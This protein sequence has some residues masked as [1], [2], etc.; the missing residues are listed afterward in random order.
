MIIISKY[1]FILIFQITR[2]LNFHYNDRIYRNLIELNAN[3]DD[4]KK[5]KDKRPISST[6][7]KRDLEPNIED[8]SEELSDQDTPPNIPV[9]KPKHKMLKLVE[10]GELHKLV[11]A[12]DNL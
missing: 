7:I 4:L 3:V 2:N 12:F 6:S 5:R 9:I 10:N 1:T 8:F 11:S